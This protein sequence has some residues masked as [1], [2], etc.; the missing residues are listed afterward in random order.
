NNNPGQDVRGQMHGSW[1]NNTNTEN[2]GIPTEA[3]GSYRAPQETLKE[4]TFVALNAP[5]EYRTATTAYGVGTSGENR[6]HGEF[7]INLAHDRFNALPVGVH[8]RPTP[9]TPSVRQSYMF[10][11]PVYI[12]KVYD[13]RNRT[14]FHFLTQP[15]SDTTHTV[16]RSYVAPT[17]KYRNGDFSEYA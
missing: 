14:F 10:S 7:F 9:Q 12:P 1:A 16:S 6:P 17:L 3:Y 13:G 2:E 11:G 8:Q 15:H 5:A 4:I